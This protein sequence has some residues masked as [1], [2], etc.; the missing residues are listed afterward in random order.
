M[1]KYEEERM[2]NGQTIWENTIVETD[3]GCQKELPVR[4][5]VISLEPD[6]H[7]HGQLAYFFNVALTALKFSMKTDYSSFG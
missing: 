3:L 5:S 7:S 4:N 1:I 2:E 6:I